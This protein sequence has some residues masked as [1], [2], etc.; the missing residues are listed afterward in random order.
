MFHNPLFAIVHSCHVLFNVPCFEGYS[1]LIVKKCLG[2][3]ESRLVK[4]P[5]K[6]TFLKK[7]SGKPGWE[8][9]AVDRDL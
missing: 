9:S 3:G 6:K 7:L 4:K 2:F 5:F 8:G 1:L